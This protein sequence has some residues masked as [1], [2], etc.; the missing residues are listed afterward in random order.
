MG[1]RYQPAK[2]NEMVKGV[3]KTDLSKAGVIGK[4]SLPEKD[5]RVG[6]SVNNS[7][8]KTSF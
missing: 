5:F 3:K 1:Q 7:W 8:V 4:E 2:K 6:L